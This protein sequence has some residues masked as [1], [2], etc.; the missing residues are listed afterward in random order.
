[1]VMPG[2]LGPAQLGTGTGI[3]FVQV[4]NLKWITGPINGQLLVLIG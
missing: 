2:E 3:K 4:A 1:M